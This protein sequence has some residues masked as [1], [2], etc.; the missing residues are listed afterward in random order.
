MPELA[1]DLSEAKGFL[2]G[3]GAKT[4]IVQIP[5][6]LKARAK[7]ISDEL[8]QACENVFVKMDPCFGA[9]DLPL[10]D[11]NAL[12]ADAIIHIGHEAIHRPKNIFYAPL[13]YEITD[14]EL[15]KICGKLVKELQKR[16]MDSIA[17][18]AN[19]QF[20][21]AL[22]EL[23]KILFRS[24]IQS[25]IG[26]GTQRVCGEGQ[27]LGCNYSAVKAVQPSVDA[28]VYFGDGMFHPLGLLYGTKKPVIVVNPLH[29]TVEEIPEKTRDTFMR[30]RFAAIAKASEA[31]SFGIVVSAKSGQRQKEKALE[32][33]KAVERQGRKAYLFEADYVNENYFTGSGV[34]CLV[35]TACNRIVIDDSQNWK[36]II[37]NPTECLIAIGEKTFDEWVPDEF[38]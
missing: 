9:C 1:I 34:D 19:A 36:T 28:N 27:I 37:I 18:V 14:A 11:L 2:R 31:R 35:I 29:G 16:K 25:N 38:A 7:W 26:K 4:C 23:R 22:P 8:S 17:L 20:I 24:G 3:K 5:E 13:R 21:H 33:R 30:R 32:L 6:G 12:N 15:E 10:Q